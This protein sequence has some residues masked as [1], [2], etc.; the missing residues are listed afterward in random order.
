MNENNFF[1]EQLSPGLEA[2]VLG[3]NRPLD[4]SGAPYVLLP[5]VTIGNIFL[6]VTSKSAT[7]TLTADDSVILV[8]TGSSALTMNLPTAV[9]LTGKRYDIKK[10][11][12]GSGTITIQSNGVETID[13]ELT[14]VVPFQWA[15]L[16][17]ISNGAGWFLI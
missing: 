9:G 5:S 14:Q 17:L 15:S 16:T 3:T 10:I 2:Q 8:T 7:Y 11:D 4:L 12:T 1:F 6:I 13:G